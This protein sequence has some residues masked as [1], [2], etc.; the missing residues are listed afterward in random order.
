MALDGGLHC[1]NTLVG[2]ARAK[3][4]LQQQLQQQQHLRQQ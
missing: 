2:E 4:D 1:I 3:M